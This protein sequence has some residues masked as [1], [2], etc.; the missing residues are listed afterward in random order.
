MVK[1]APLNPYLYDPEVVGDISDVLTPPYDVIGP[2]EQAMYRARS[3]Y[4]AVHI[5]LPEASDGRSPYQNAASLVERWVEEGALRTLR[6]PALFIHQQ[7]FELDGAPYARTSLLAGVKLEPWEARVVLPHERTF[8][9]PKEDRLALWR[10]TT[11]A[12]STLFGLYEQPAEVAEI[13]ARAIETQPMLTAQEAGVTHLLWALDDESVVGAVAD[14]LA[15]RQVYIADGHHRYETA[16]AYRDERR[17]E[18]P[19]T[20]ADAA[21]NYVAM[22][23]VAFDDPGLVVLPTHR[24]V[25]GVAHDVA[26]GLA[27]RLA[28]RMTLTPVEPAKAT[29][30][31][32]ARLLEGDEAYAFLLYDGQTMYRTTA[33]A[34]LADELSSDRSEAWRSLDLA[35]L[36]EFVF[37]QGLHLSTEEAERCVGYTRDV[38]GAMERVRSGD[39]QLAAF[40]R[41]T[42]VAQLRAV[43]DASDRM[44]QKS[45]YFYPKFPAGLVVNRLDVRLPV[46][47][48]ATR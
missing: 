29:E 27:G 48:E 36:H 8:R 2:A 22:S 39:A 34:S 9:G 41:P 40:V 25:A 33:D 6:A 44:P 14:S 16:L 32:V 42:D 3:P 7:R 20:H 12:P 17:A 31:E 19:D 30:Q 46:A 4:S 11:V 24:I 45:T 5:E 18:A 43:A 23:L 10:A 35:A 28:D 47:V 26:A 38:P 13:V 21:Y 15:D 37:A 1:I